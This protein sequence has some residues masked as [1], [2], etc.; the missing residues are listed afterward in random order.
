MVDAG[1]DGLDPP[2]VRRDL[3]EA[4]RHVERDRDLGV[5]P[6]RKLGFVEGVAR[7]GNVVGEHTEVRR[8]HDP[9]IG[10]ALAQRRQRLVVGVPRVRDDHGADGARLRHGSP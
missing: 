3:A 4:L 2:Q 6:E 9:E 10:Q 5:G 8:R 7:T 1:A